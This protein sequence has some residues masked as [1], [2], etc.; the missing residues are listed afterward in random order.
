MIDTP[1]IVATAAQTTAVIRLHVMRADIEA[2]MD[3]AL[4]ELLSV[5]QAQGV[6]PAGPLFT[7]HL[8]R[9][10]ESFEF[11]VGFPVASNIVPFGRVTMSE[12]PAVR[13]AHTI[14]RGGYE[15]LAGAWGELMRWI[16]E[17]GLN[18]AEWL[19]EVYRVGPE[20]G[21]NSNSWET[22]LYRPL[23]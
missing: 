12:L 13:T 15:G 2:A 14:C 19:W 23:R 9:P 1:Q 6:P 22:D 7:R 21:L 4:G 11:E 17:Q 16:A 20:S 3:A 5:L 10:S 18:D 8:R